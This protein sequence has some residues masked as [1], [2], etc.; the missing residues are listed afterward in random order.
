MIKEV[1]VYSTLLLTANTIAVRIEGRYLRTRSRINRQSMMSNAL[2][3]GIRH[4]FLDLSQLEE[5]DLTAPDF[6]GSGLYQM[7]N[8]RPED[9]ISR[10][11]VYAPA[12]SYGLGIARMYEGFASNFDGIEVHSNHDADAAIAWL[13]VTAT[14][15]D[16]RRDTGWIIRGTEAQRP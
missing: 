8:R 14:Y 6:L 1:G 12:G 15:A 9:E 7:A 2:A 10:Q 3:S 5:T 16:L 13:G 11:A 4:L